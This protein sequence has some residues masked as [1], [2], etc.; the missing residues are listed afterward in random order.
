MNHCLKTDSEVAHAVL[1]FMQQ[2]HPLALSAALL[3]LAVVA[4]VVGGLISYAT[5]PSPISHFLHGDRSRGDAIRRHL[6][7]AVGQCLAVA[8][9]CLLVA[10]WVAWL[11]EARD[12]RRHSAQKYEAYC[13]SATQ[14]LLPAAVLTQV[15]LPAAQRAYSAGRDAEGAAKRDAPDRGAAR[16]FGYEACV[17]EFSEEPAIQIG[18][19]PFRLQVAAGNSLQDADVLPQRHAINDLFCFCRHPISPVES[20]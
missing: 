15:I 9:G 3:A 19:A 11:Q 13:P 5:A 18:R 2:A 7:D 16:Q 20:T 10:G 6:L 14:E 4:G 17:K 8:I 12:G 1:Q